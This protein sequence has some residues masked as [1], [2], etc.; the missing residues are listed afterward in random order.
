METFAY[1]ALLPARQTMQRYG[2]ADRTFDRWL[3]DPAL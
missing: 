3:A 1:D 2:I